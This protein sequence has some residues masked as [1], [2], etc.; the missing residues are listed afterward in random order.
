[1]EM[2]LV[3]GWAGSSPQRG[4]LY[5]KGRLVFAFLIRR[6][7]DD[8]RAHPTVTV[9]PPP[10]QKRRFLGAR[11]Y[12]GFTS[13]EVMR[14]K[15]REFSKSL[16]KTGDLGGGIPYCAGRGVSISCAAQINLCLK[17]LVVRSVRNRPTKVAHRFASRH[18]DRRCGG[19]TRWINGS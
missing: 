9:A 6:R 10:N 5:R 8:G 19:V 3:R 13:T 14:R 4:D 1:M 16:G 18:P 11:F 12:K 17:V 15:S 2:F 7:R